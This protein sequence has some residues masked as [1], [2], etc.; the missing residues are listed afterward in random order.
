[1][2]IGYQWSIKTPGPDTVSDRFK[3][4]CILYTWSGDTY[5]FTPCFNHP[6]GLGNG[7]LRIHGVRGGHGLDPNGIIS[8]N[9]Y[10]SNH[11]AAG[12][13]SLVLS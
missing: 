4:F 11:D 7:S 10:I 6:N 2:N 12:S 8:T 1:M 5:N 9:T 13:P 3:I